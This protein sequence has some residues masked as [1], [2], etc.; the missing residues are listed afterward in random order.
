[1]SFSARPS[2]SRSS[3]PRSTSRNA[4]EEESIYHSAAPSTMQGAAPLVK[5]YNITTSKPP[6]PSVLSSPTGGGGP[7]PKMHADSS[8]VQNF[9]NPIQGPRDAAKRAGIKPPDHAKSNIQAIREQSSLNQLRK[10]EQLDSEAR[11]GRNGA[12]FVRSASANENRRISGSGVSNQYYNSQQTDERQG[13]DFVRENKLGAVAPVRL[14]RA[15]DADDGQKFLKKKD[16]GR[17]PTYLLERK[18]E[19]VEQHDAELK[20]KEAALIP[21][22]MRLLADEERL[23]TLFALQRNKGE[24]ERA[25]QALP[26]RIETQSQIRWRDDLERRMREV[27]EGIKVFSR[28]KVLVQA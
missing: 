5:Q 4:Q 20:A 14:P 6:V 8:Q 24:V 12:G 9:F 16:Y 7:K 19:L 17:V 10:Q 2:S 26:L 1:M 18:L 15:Q 28:P 22:G 13:R 21:A 11:G 3:V 23:E 25:M 27:D